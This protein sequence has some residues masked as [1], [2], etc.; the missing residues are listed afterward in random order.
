MARP[1]NS[2]QRRGEILD[3]MQKVLAVRGYDG[4]TIA[5]VARAAGLGAGLVHYHFKSKQEILVSLVDRIRRLVE[6]RYE[7][8][9]AA[10]TDEPLGQLFAFIDAHVARGEGADQSAVAAWVT[11]GAEAISNPEVRAL[12]GET[13]HRRIRELKRLFGMVLKQ[14]GRSSQG[15]HEMAAAVAAAIE[16]TFQIASVAPESLPKGFAARALHRMAVG[17]LGEDQ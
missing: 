9:R 16:G 14:Q 12:Y 4:A 8:R 6:D 13:M 11:I 2:L 10:G 5:E 15:A 1:S 17:L 7:R 3:A